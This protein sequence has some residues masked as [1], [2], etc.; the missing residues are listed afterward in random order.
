MLWLRAITLGVAMCFGAQA[1]AQDTEA[2]AS[3]ILTVDQDRLFLETRLAL[4]G[5]AAI[6]AEALALA[7]ENRRIE[8]E[9]GAEERQ[10]TDR[11]EG[12][13]PEEFT[14]LADAFDEKVQRIRAEQDAKARALSARQEAA[15]QAFFVEIGG[16]LSDI[17]RERDADI[18]L[19]RRNVFLS[20]DRVDITDEVI[21]RVNALTDD[22]NGSENSDDVGANDQ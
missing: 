12:L 15:R 14:A 18:V 3:R 16:I 10:L 7:E 2:A 13:T 6:E 9:L 1:I 17:V 5:T 4:R 21:A 11:R 22:D 8:D 19:D 20:A